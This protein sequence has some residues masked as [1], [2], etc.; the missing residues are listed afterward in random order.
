MNGRQTLGIADKTDDWKLN[1]LLTRRSQMDSV[2]VFTNH[3]IVKSGANLKYQ[4]KD[5]NNSD[6]EF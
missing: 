3:I 1:R 2:W 5:Y 4:V 6:E